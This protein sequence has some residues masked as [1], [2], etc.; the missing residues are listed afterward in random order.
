MKVIQQNKST[1]KG[2]SIAALILVSGSASLA[3]AQVSNNYSARAFYGDPSNSHVVSINLPDMTLAGNSPTAL[4]PYPVDRAGSDHRLYA[5]TR[6]VNSVDI[7]DPVSLANT[8]QIQLSHKPRSGEAYNSKLGLQLIAGADKAMTSVIDPS[9]DSVVGVAGD[10]VITTANGDYGGGNAS[11]HPFW[12]SKRK[13]AV[14]D[15]AN[16]KIKLYKINGDKTSGF[17]VKY[18]DQINTPT[19]VHHFVKRDRDALYGR[20]KYIYYAVAEGAPARGIAPKLIK[21]EVR[22]RRIQK[23]KSVSLKGFDPA[24]MGSHHADLHPGGK[25][26]Y[27]GSAEGHLFVINRLSMKIKAVIET[28][29]GTGHTR[30]I[31]SRDL[32]II[33]NHK[34]TFVTVVDTKHH[35]K[36]SDVT[37]SGPQVNGTI[38]QSHT[39]FVDP[40]AEHFYAFASDNGE[41]YELDL[42]ILGVSRTL[43]TGGTPLQGVILL[44]DDDD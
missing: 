1:L 8:G 17:S 13:F 20:D 4:T 24:T 31:P 33:T 41:F 15:R 43:Y 44:N 28:G 11:G 18:L 32:A 19:T 30:F 25:F 37:V 22:G 5:I 36:I 21:I 16:R 10:D 29:K 3:S 23:L 6:G 2:I 35:Q 40:D 26:I 38:L 34:D 9:T 42:N 27:M 7:I 12:F 14:I 39:S